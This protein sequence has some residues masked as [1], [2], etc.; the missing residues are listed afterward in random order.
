M[1][2]QNQYPLFDTLIHANYVEQ[3]SEISEAAII[4]EDRTIFSEFLK[5][6][7]YFDILINSIAPSIHDMKAEKTALLL[8]M[9]GGVPKNSNSHKIRGDINVLLLGDPGMGKSQ[10]LKY[11]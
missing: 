7:N 11:V 8:S 1:S 2:A 6:P 5:N 4:D 3:E 10:L 9:V